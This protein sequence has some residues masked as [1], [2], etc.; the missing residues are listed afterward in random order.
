ME[1]RG[2]GARRPQGDG[3]RQLFVCRRRRSLS[4]LFAS[5]FVGVCAEGRLERLMSQR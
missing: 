4:L 1:E 3:G 2:G 5:S